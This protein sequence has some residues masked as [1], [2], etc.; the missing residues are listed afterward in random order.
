MI[1]KQGT[2]K[3]FTGENGVYYVPETDR[4][5]L[6]QDKK[7]DMRFDGKCLRTYYFYNVESDGFKSDSPLV[8]TG[9]AE[10]FLMGDF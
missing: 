8:I 1:I 5:F 9:N 4:I 7:F 10:M 3:H 6:I 2:P